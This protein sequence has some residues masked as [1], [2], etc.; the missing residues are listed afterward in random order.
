MIDKQEIFQQAQKFKLMPNIIEKDY[1]IG[2]ILY[3]IANNTTLYNAWVFKGGTCLKKCFFKEYRFSED[4]DFTVID[5]KQIDLDFLKEQFISIASWIYEKTGI[6]L[7]EE[8]IIFETYKNP[9]GNLSIT[10]KISY[11][12]PMQRRGDLPTIKLDLTNDE[13]VAAT[14]DRKEID[15]AYSDCF[16]NYIQCYCYI[17]IFAE[18]IRALIERLRPR[19]VYDVVHLYHAKRDL[20]VKELLRIL[21]IKCQFKNIEI[22]NFAELNQRL[23][24]QELIVEWSSMLSHQINNLQ[25]LDYFWEQ[26]ELFFQWLNFS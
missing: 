24:R 5:P 11:R 19:D 10:G 4:L 9:R 25:P 18:K 14:S 12:G 6:K 7:P 20:N 1:V 23:E 22:Q 2:W 17:E 21:I 3:G 8:L 15:H 16:L 26:L 13:I